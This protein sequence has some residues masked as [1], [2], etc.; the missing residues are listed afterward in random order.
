MTAN[1]IISPF[2]LLGWAINRDTYVEAIVGTNL[3]QWG[4]TE[5][6]ATKALNPAN[7]LPDYPPVM[8]P[9]VGMQIDELGYIPIK[10]PPA[11][12]APPPLVEGYHLNFRIYIQE[13]KAAL[14]AYI[15]TMPVVQPERGVP[16]CSQDAYGMKWLHLY[17]ADGKTPTIA[18][19]RRIWA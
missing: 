4:W 3:T 9:G 17:Q 18:T 13:L 14:D 12:P 8:V 1:T 16:L 7:G 15:A 19:R 5:K 10:N 6:L 11:P 2:E